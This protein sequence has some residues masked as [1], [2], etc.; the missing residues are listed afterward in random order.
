M[1]HKDEGGA[2]ADVRFV[3]KADIPVDA[4]LVEWAGPER[5]RFSSVPHSR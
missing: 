4:E 5:L 2:A 1:R 3:P